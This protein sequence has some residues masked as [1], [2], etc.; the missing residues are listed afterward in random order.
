M[1]CSPLTRDEMSYQDILKAPRFWGLLLFPSLVSFGAYFIIVHH[2]KYLTDFGVDK[3]WAASLFAGIGALSSGFRFFWGW[4][5]DRR[6]REITFTLGGA[7]FSLGILFLL[8]FQYIPSPLLLY[9]FALF[10]GSGW[11]VTAPMFMSITG[12]LYKGKNFG[13]IYG[14]VEGAIG[15]GSALGA[16]VAG[17]I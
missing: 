1:V 11:G 13:L 7:C 10:F 15:L 2:V 9:L 6:G 16:W 12:D 4:F 3:M 14:M 8:L 17:Y 5:S